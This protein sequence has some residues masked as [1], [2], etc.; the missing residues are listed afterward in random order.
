MTHVGQQVGNALGQA[1]ALGFHDL[2]ERIG[3][4]RQK[5]AGRHGRHPLLDREAHAVARFLVTLY[6]LGHAGQHAAAE[7]I[8]GCGHRRNRIGAPFGLG[9]ALV[10]GQ[11]GLNL[12][13]I[14]K[15][16]HGLEILLLQPLQFGGIELNRLSRAGRHLGHGRLH[17]LRDGGPGVGCSAQTR[18]G[19][20]PHGGTGL[21]LLER[22]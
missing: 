17:G 8:V 14:R 6:C 21:H 1:L 16:L 9:E 10:P 5:I 20:E 19:A 4:Q 11:Q 7:Q 15:R 22:L 12:I 18:H 13:G 2:V 3:I